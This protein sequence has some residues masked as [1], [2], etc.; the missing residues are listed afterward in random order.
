MLPVYEKLVDA[1]NARGGAMPALRGDEFYALLEELYTP[2]EAELALQMPLTP[3]SAQALA[4]A[5]GRDIE[6]VRESLE[7]MAD[8]GLVFS[9]EHDG[10]LLYELWALLPGVF[11]LQF[12]RGEVNERTRKLA[13]LFDDYFNAIGQPLPPG[14][15]VP[16]LVPFARVITVEKE[17]PAGVRIHTHDRV[18]EYIAHTEDIGLCTCYCRHMAELLGEPCAKPKDVCLVFGDWAKFIVARGFGR[19]ISQAE[20]RTVLDRA[21][22]AGLIH[23]SSN[24]GAQL[25][26]ICNCCSCHCGI[27]QSVK[28]A[29]RPSMAAVSSFLLR[30]DA[31][32][33]VGC[34]A[35]LERCQLDALSMDGDV[36]VRDENRCVGCGLC[37]RVCPTGALKLEARGDA[38]TPPA[39]WGKL[40]QAIIASW[41]QL[42]IV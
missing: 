21:E 24:T 26:F 12:V 31:E 32:E 23:C 40:N 37:V 41:R 33:C 16:R 28:A 2:D 4:A 22:D 30:V 7:A 20:A 1:L 15:E 8:K 38:A 3:L 42:G 39:D 13:R 14:V 10:E 25:G 34:G 11:E 19:P 29:G 35:C 5:T 6:A 18:S 27:I 36:A 9:R 17:I